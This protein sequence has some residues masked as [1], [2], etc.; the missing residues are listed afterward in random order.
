MLGNGMRFIDLEKC[1]EI[2]VG[3]MFESS[4][5]MSHVICSHEKEGWLAMVLRELFFFWLIDV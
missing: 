3:N 1:R 5:L 2:L 4:L